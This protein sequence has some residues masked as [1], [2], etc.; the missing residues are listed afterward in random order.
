M[1]DS[2]RDDRRHSLASMRIGYVLYWLDGVESGVFRKVCN[3]VRFWVSAGHEVTLVLAGPVERQ[4]AYRAAVESTGAKLEYMPLQ[5]SMGRWFR[6]RKLKSVLQRNSFSA[7]YHRFDLATPGLASAMEPGKWIVEINTNDV[8]E[9]GLHLSF[10]SV[11]N[12]VSRNKFFRRA[13]A[14]VFPTHEL[15]NDSVFGAFN[16]AREVIANGADFTTIKAAP[17]AMGPVHLL[18]MG[19]DGHSWHGIDKLVDLAAACPDWQIHA[20]GVSKAMFP[21]GKPENINAP[22]ALA[23]SQYEPLAAASTVGIGTLALHRKGM[24]EACP[25]KVR[26]YLAYGLPVILGYKDTDVSKDAAYALQL[27]N[28]EN[29]VATHL[30]EIRDFVEGWR[31]R[32]VPREMVKQMDWSVKE[33]ARLRFIGRVCGAPVGAVSKS[34]SIP[35]G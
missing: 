7:I 34:V 1:V 33:Q 31:G 11:Y 24:E 5:G 35:K 17:P 30:K 28:A 3:Q 32:R 2:D 6:W 22:G 25:L 29:N 8:A 16:D 18:F 20:V 12:R 23:R 14:G 9:Y 10:R 19:S 26:E 15:A 13:A 27:P 21:N 4:E